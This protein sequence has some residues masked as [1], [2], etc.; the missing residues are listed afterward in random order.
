MNTREHAVDGQIG[1]RPTG[2]LLSN[3]HT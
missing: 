3:R 2:P 1:N